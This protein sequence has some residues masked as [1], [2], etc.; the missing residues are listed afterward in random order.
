MDPKSKSVFII[1][2]HEVN[3]KGRLLVHHQNNH[4]ETLTLK[5]D[6][7]GVVGVERKCELPLQPSHSH[8]YHVFPNEYRQLYVRSLDTPGMLERVELRWI[9]EE[10]ITGDIC[11]NSK[12]YAFAE[13]EPLEMFQSTGPCIS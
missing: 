6:H 10:K 8:W 5:F 7:S 12:E 13:W 11:R 9:G 3:A 4:Q 2:I 1:T